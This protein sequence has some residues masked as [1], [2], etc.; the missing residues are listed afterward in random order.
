MKRI[1]L[2]LIV[3]FSPVR[4]LWIDVNEAPKDLLFRLTTAR[5]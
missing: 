4:L 1:A 2:L 5:L 3:D